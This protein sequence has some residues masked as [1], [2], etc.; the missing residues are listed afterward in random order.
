M[1]EITTEKAKLTPQ[2]RAAKQVERQTAYLDRIAFRRE[3]DAELGITKNNAKYDAAEKVARARLI[4][5]E[6][7][8]G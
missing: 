3:R 2:G 1:S 6:A 5:A 8:A 4:I 7:E